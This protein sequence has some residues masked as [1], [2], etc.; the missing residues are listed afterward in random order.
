MYNICKYILYYNIYVIC[1]ENTILCPTRKRNSLA[2]LNELSPG[3]L[4]FPTTGY[5][6]VYTT[7]TPH[8][9]VT[10]TG[11]R[12]LTLLLVKWWKYCNKQVFVTA[13]MRSL[14]GQSIIHQLLFLSKTVILIGQII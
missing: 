3:V 12:Q 10:G 9:I 5:L 14:I 4:N 11:I 2:H 7:I 8:S 6:N 13:G 1:Y